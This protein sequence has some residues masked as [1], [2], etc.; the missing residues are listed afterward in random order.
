MQPCPLPSVNGL[1]RQTKVAA[2]PPTDLHD[3]ERR[4]WARIDGQE[5]DLSP[6]DPNVPPEHTPAGALKARGDPRLGRV[7]GGLGRGPYR[8]TMPD[9]GYLPLTSASELAAHHHTCPPGK[10]PDPLQ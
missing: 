10:A 7:A 9:G 5:V 6:P 1:L 2:R 8:W 3:H 4:R